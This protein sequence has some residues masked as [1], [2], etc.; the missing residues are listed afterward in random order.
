[1]I[2]FICCMMML[3]KT[4][5]SFG[6]RVG[7]L[8]SAFPGTLPKP[9]LRR[10]RST[11]SRSFLN[12]CPRFRHMI[13]NLSRPKDVPG[14][15][16]C[17]HQSN[18]K[19][20]VRSTRCREAPRP[21]PQIPARWLRFQIL[22]RSLSGDSPKQLVACANSLPEDSF[23]VSSKKKRQLFPGLVPTST[24]SQMLPYNIHVLVKKY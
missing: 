20:R 15:P 21:L 13:S 1:M 4:P 9:A 16:S 10:F 17:V 3:M 8:V 22:A 2:C 11:R 24:S 19:N 18:S 12:P 5:G 23:T 7:H 14:L 6:N